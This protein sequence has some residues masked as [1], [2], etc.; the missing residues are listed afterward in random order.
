MNKQIEE[1]AKVICFDCEN[2]SCAVC[3]DHDYCRSYS[4]ASNL[5]NAGYR[6]I[7]DVTGEIFAEIAKCLHIVNFPFINSE[8][9]LTPIHA[10]YLAIYPND[11][12]ELKKKYESE[13]IDDE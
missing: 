3:K 5:Y 6:K 12:A 8:G 4:V 9:C 2:R 10:P 1:M 13:G 11:L 7:A